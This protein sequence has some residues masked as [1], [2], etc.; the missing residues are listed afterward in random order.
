LNWNGT[1]WQGVAFSLLAVCGDIRGN[2]AFFAPKEDDGVEVL[3]YEAG[4]HRPRR[5][6]D[7][8]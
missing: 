4:W 2:P 7:A 1:V 3:V 6:P 5:A 8:E